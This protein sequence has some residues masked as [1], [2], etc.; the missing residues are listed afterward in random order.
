M[1]H[2][3]LLIP[4]LLFSLMGCASRFQYM[5]K[6]PED[7]TK[8]T[9]DQLQAFAYDHYRLGDHVRALRFVYRAA[10]SDPTD[11]RSALLMGL[12]YD[13]GFDRP[14]LAIP[15]YERVTPLRPWSNL[16]KRLG[17]RLY[18][19]RQR[20]ETHRLE[21]LLS[22]GANLPASTY[23]I[24]VLPFEQTGPRDPQPG[25]SLGLT[26]MVLHGL[27]AAE[28]SYRID[29]LKLHI[30]HRAYLR[31]APER[32]NRDFATWCGA[33]TVLTGTLT[34]L[35]K[36]RLRLTVM[37]LG[38]NGKQLYESSP[39]VENTEN[40]NH[41]YHAL[42]EA[43]H[44]AFDL[45]GAPNGSP[46]PVGNALALLI[47][48]HALELYLDGQSNAADLFL[49]QALEADPDSELIGR[50]LGWVARDIAGIKAEHALVSAY[51]K[52]MEQS[53][54]LAGQP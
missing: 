4:F 38:P 50:T 25:L 29:P 2:S 1:K 31:Q 12:I 11:L 9:N 24:T 37:L 22:S 28:D 48:T 17:Q 33:D 18:H 44:E 46:L 14:D 27:A 53:L 39:I 36:G 23:P 34:D 13:L 7:P 32:S 10:A 8:L 54:T 47:H 19:L 40:L 41:L 21:R 52:I 3:P 45:N 42:M 30:L 20:S 5:A 15:E 6:P 35:G 51:H 43:V 49:T 16:P 26:D